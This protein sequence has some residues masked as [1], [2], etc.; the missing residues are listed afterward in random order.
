[1][2]AT[3]KVKIAKRDARGRFKAAVGKVTGNKRTQARGEADQAAAD[4]EQAAVKAKDG[5][6]HAATAK[7]KA[8]GAAK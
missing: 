4:V 6:T 8:R 2:S 3:T 5:V 7:K 1:M